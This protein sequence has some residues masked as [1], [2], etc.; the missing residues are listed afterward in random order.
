M[1]N[2][3]CHM[4]YAFQSMCDVHIVKFVRQ[5]ASSATKETLKQLI[6]KYQCLQRVWC[7][8]GIGS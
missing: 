7:T 1:S 3:N 4:P 5:D 6:I 8:T 2:V